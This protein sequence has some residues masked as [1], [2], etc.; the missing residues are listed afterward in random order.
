MNDDWI[1][2]I[3]QFSPEDCFYLWS[4]RSSYTIG[5]L[6][7]TLTRMRYEQ[8]IQLILKDKFFTSSNNILFRG[9]PLGTSLTA[10]EK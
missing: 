5:N 10:I 6:I 7:K 1:M 2:S 4:L 3:P 9:E 8:L